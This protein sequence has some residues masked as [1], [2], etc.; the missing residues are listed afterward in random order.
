MY[1]IT[2]F[3]KITNDHLAMAK[4]TY[5]MLFKY[6]FVYLVHMSKFAVDFVLQ[7]IAKKL[8]S[9]FN[10]SSTFQLNI[11]L[12]FQLHTLRSTYSSLAAN[13]AA[14]LVYH[15]PTL[16]AML[17]AS[18]AESCCSLQT[19]QYSIILINTVLY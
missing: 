9:T 5:C 14:C 4:L 15:N 12:F 2:K 8:N 11:L 7:H 3:R 17:A 18:Y 19:K 6:D 13:L 10:E 16:M 1:C